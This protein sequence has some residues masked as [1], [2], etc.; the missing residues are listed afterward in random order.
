MG[1]MGHTHRREGR[2]RGQL[3]LLVATLPPRPVT[4]TL[5]HKRRASMRRALMEAWTRLLDFSTIFEIA[6]TPTLMDTRSINVSALLVFS[7]CGKCYIGRLST[8]PNIIMLILL[9]E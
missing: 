8:E 7:L 9:R 6:I 1:H 2:S 5:M 4:M 3:K